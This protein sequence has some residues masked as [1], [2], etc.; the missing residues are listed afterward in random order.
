MNKNILSGIV[1]AAGTVIVIS[2]FLPW[3]K[4]SISAVGVSKELAKDAKIILKD[5]PLAGKLLG[6]LE[7][8]TDAIGALGDVDVKTQVTGYGIPVLVNRKISKVAFSLVQ[9][10]FKSAANVDIKSYLVYL[11]PLLGIFCG[12]AAILG[13]KN[14]LYIIIMLVVAGLVSIAGLY[15]LYTADLSNIAVKIT[16]MNGLWFTM[17]GFLFIFLVGIAWLILDKKS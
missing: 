8:A 3:A 5:T 13:Q 14:K 15:N 1:I 2:F 7:K 12:V 6:R 10:M 16:I 4:V 17:Y 9:I 11:L